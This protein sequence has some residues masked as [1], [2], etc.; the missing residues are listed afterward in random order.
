MNLYF[1]SRKDNGDDWDTYDSAVVCAASED[2][3]RN[4]SPARYSSAWVTPETE[5]VWEIF[6]GELWA[7]MRKMY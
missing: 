3:A 7:W 5:I 4:I 1:I 6:L 2:D